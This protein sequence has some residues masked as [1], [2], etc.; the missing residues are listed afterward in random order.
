MNKMKRLTTLED[1]RK[2]KILG[3]IAFF[4]FQ[5]Y[6]KELLKRKQKHAIKTGGTF[7]HLDLA[8]ANF[9]QWIFPQYPPYI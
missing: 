2:R 4:H 5:I 8:W 9:Y 1:L 3:I 7:T 6:C